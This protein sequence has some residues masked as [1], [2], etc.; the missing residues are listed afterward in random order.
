ME[1][2]PKILVLEDDPKMLE[3]LVDIL[4]DH[5]YD[6]TPASNGE[7][8]VAKAME[9]SF[10]LII[11]DIRMEGMSGLDAVEKS[12][13]EQPEMGT[14]IVSGYATPDNMARAMQLQAGKI[15]SKPFKTK[16]FLK[17]V[18]EQ[19]ALRQKHQA[20]RSRADRSEAELL[21]AVDALARTIDRPAPGI[22]A[23]H[24]RTLAEGMA[25]SAGLSS[26]VSVEVGLAAALASV[27]DFSTPSEILEHATT[28]STLKYCLSHYD[29][30]PES[31]SQARLE[32]RIVAFA[33]EVVG[34]DWDSAHPPPADSLDAQELSSDLVDLYQKYLNGGSG[35]R[36]RRSEQEQ[37]RGALSLAHTLWGLG[38][39]SEARKAFEQLRK[40]SEG[41]LLITSLLGQAHLE[42][43][44]GNAEAVAA[45]AR[46][47]IA[48]ARG[49]GPVAY[50]TTLLASG[51]LI[52]QAGSDASTILKEAIQELARLR[53]DGSV[54][55]AAIAMS[56]LGHQP[57]PQKL[58]YFLTAL[59]QP[60]YSEEV[61]EAAGWLVPASL[62]L[63]A[64]SDNEDNQKA[65]IRL[66]GRLAPT[67]LS[68]FRSERTSTEEKTAFLKALE[69]N[70]GLAPTTLL[71]ELATDRDAD[72]ARRA[73]TLKGAQSTVS[74]T[75]VIRCRSFGV[76][77][78]F[79]GT[80]MVPDKDW[81]T[82]KV[83]YYFAYL[84]SQWGTYQADD[85]IIEQFWPN[86]SKDKGKQ[87]LYWSTS[88]LR[89]CVGGEEQSL[90]NLVERRE[91]SLRLSPDVLHWHDLQEFESLLDAGNK[92]VRAEEWSK[93]RHFLSQMAEVC[94]GPYL[95]GYRQAWAEQKREQL[96]LRFQE[97]LRNLAH[98][99]LELEDH[100]GT[101]E[102]ARR[103]LELDNSI[104]SGHEYAMRAY[105][106]EGN[107][108][109]AIQQYEQCHKILSDEYGLEPSPELHALYEEAYSYG[110]QELPR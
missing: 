57:N 100:S 34:E 59:V 15:L 5:D 51:L 83:R 32:A 66:L 63:L 3:V 55:L 70:S 22:P 30:P 76:F 36:E 21:W 38:R 71:E 73:S 27:Q 8:A 60:R 53:F 74:E 93:A 110:D 91:E 1:S 92:A 75:P 97:G 78:V 19:L 28:L 14:L 104:E 42:L 89:K 17:R 88:M 43:G 105:I 67:V 26:E 58:N 47:S 18:E 96:N 16:E 54:A 69:T 46:E 44:E 6:V 86:K 64:R 9:S 35:T 37:L 24:Y 52:Y 31:L 25:L 101:L 108:T 29:E 106:G 61:M 50:A 48:K 102:A 62:K 99:C 65:I 80:E 79:R 87:N 13:L 109:Q 23:H 98:C 72:I 2:Q 95:E 84:A 81:K 68:Y 77:Q 49:F 103:L 39:V 4:Q 85:V 11:A 7:E 82:K 12:R 20:K 45:L 94:T 56:D 107:Y 33:L 10:D 40:K 41:R 90:K